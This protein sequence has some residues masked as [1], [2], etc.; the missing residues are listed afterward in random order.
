MDPPAEKKNHSSSGDA[1]RSPWQVLETGFSRSSDDAP[2]KDKTPT[3]SHHNGMPHSDSQGSV[4]KAAD[5]DAA[6]HPRGLGGD[7]TAT[8]REPG[9]HGPSLVRYQG[10]TGR[11]RIPSGGNTR[12]PKSP[13]P[14]EEHT[15]L[16]APAL[17]KSPG[18]IPS[19]VN[20]IGTR[21]APESVQSYDDATSG[22]TESWFDWFSDKTEELP[23]L[24]PSHPLSSLTPHAIAILLSHYNKWRACAMEQEQEQEQGPPSAPPPNGLSPTHNRRKRPKF[25]HA[26][27]DDDEDNGDDDGG[28]SPDPNST[29][30]KQSL[31]EST[32]TFSCPFL[33]KDS[34]K[35]G[36]CSKYMLSRIRDV[37]QHLGRKHQMPIYCPRCIET[38]S[39]EDSRDEHN[40]N[41][42]CERS[43]LGKPEGI[44]EA[45]KKALGKKAPANQS[46]EEQWYGIFDILFPNHPRP[47]SPYI[48]S[49]LLR[50][51]FVYQSFLASNGPR[52]LSSILESSGAMSWNPPPFP[53]SD[54]QLWREQV[55]AQAFQQLF[56]RW[57]TMGALANSNTTTDTP[58][59][60]SAATGAVGTS[61]AH[62]NLPLQHSIETESN[63]AIGDDLY[64]FDVIT[65][66]TA[67]SVSE[68]LSWQSESD[69]LT[70]NAQG[71]VVPSPFGPMG[72]AHYNGSITFTPYDTQE[73]Q[74]TFSRGLDFY[75]NGNGN[76][77]NTNNNGNNSGHHNNNNGHNG[78][79]HN[80]HYGH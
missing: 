53:Q 18:L 36:E 6:S 4:V 17:Q 80:M 25:S 64:R 77:N 44:T 70:G 45:Q 32:V 14:P 39:D 55:L 61:S 47:A 52:I 62:M 15:T 63:S 22:T 69:F 37:K 72:T 19:R 79:Q 46:Q 71:G 12:G 66:E 3:M 16:A 60:T 29:R 48:D 23:I 10:E 5:L 75:S 51:A 26:G 56:D 74:Q 21:L 31:N 2:A 65:S 58:F 11:K 9:D 27:R 67:S 1:E 54:V 13:E 59:N 7:Q 41:V 20:E 38:F 49:A 68:I 24:A 50:N 35:H 78:R 43:Q 28:R 57:A 73:L 30:K 42:D 8:N 40:R 33:K 76:D 34:T